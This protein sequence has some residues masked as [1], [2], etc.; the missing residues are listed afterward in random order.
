MRPGHKGRG[1]RAP[2]EIIVASFHFSAQVIGRG[3]GRSAIAAAAYRAGTRLRDEAAGIE[4]DY[5][6]RTGVVH[7]EIIVPDGAA[8]WLAD[9]QKLW[10]HVHQIEVRRDAQLARELN[11]ALPFEL[12]ADERRELVLGF[13]REH[14]TARGMVADIAI[15]EPGSGDQRNHHAHIM[16]T[17]RQAT[18][19]GLRRVKTREW[20]S[21]ALL[22]AWREAWATRQN[23][24]LERGQHAVRVDHRTLAAQREAAQTRGDHV[25][26]AALRREPEVHVGPR[27]QKAGERQHAPRSRV[28]E[29]RTAR[30]NAGAWRSSPAPE[31]R[32]RAVDYP[33]I[34]R[35]HRLAYNAGRVAA[36]AGTFQRQVERAQLRGARLRQIE[37]RAQRMNRQAEEGLREV[38]AARSAPFWRR[39]AG[40]TLAE[41]EALFTAKRQ[42]ARRRAQL[43]RLLLGRVDGILAGLFQV[44]EHTLRRRQVLW[45]RGLGRDLLTQRSRASGRGRSRTLS[46]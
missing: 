41:R 13:V 27:A 45:D 2:P 18:P 20:N 24:F 11:V 26:A 22:K 33:Q 16:L 17:L 25:A 31:K 6:R 38:A 7:T 32:A 15:H 9:R 35:G 34:D 29:R 23:L 19:D 30:P 1:R 8:A 14:F 3:K 44:H 5:R 10:S 37:A 42:Q 39:P 46:P 43:V 40:V 4:H 12:S 28:Q 36:N 21:D